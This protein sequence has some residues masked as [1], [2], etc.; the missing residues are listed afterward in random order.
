MPKSKN[1]ICKPNVS[2][3]TPNI[4]KIHTIPTEKIIL[5]IEIIVALWADGIILFIDSDWIGYN[6]ECY[7]YQNSS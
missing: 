7:S 6:K 1:V 4:R 2:A 5:S 3:V